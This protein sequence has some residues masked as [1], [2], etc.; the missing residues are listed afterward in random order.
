MK[1]ALDA[2]LSVGTPTGI[3]EYVLGLAASLRELGI[4]VVE[5]YD[6]GVDP[7]RFDRRFWWDQVALP[8]RARDS[9]AQLLH[10]T[11]GT[12]PLSASQPI[13]VTVHDVAWLRVQAHERFYARLYFG[14]F[15]LQRYRSARRIAVDSQFSRREL[16][17]LLPGYDEQRIEV[18]Y[19]G[20]ARDFCELTRG[21]GDGRTILVVGTVE[22]RKNLEVIV[23]ALAEIADARLVSV[24]PPTPYQRECAELASS[25]G[26][27]DR[28]EFAG[29]VARHEL[30]RFYTTCAV[31]A[32]P[33]R[34]EGFGYSAAQALC[35]GVPCVVSD[36]G[37]LPEIAGED[38]KI[39]A[40][41]DP[42][43]WAAALAAALRGECNDGA[44]SARE[45]AIARFAW[46]SSARLMAVLYD[47]ALA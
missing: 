12:M 46:P 5:L 4:D 31:V 34:Y 27:G 28:V 18:V 47:A 36:Q 8:A 38:A 24:G 37:S 42:D 20:V 17:E 35:G 7:W 32:Q 21:N 2:Q 15:S 33:S 13:V 39:V 41:D 9:G 14:P 22:R 43:A 45:R 40:V 10:C 1:V 26:V 25:L 29:Y 6:A 30:L 19:P 16:I 3:G 44:R 23:R 11:S